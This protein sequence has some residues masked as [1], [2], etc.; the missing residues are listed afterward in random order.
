MILK[1]SETILL[2][3]DSEQVLNLTK[4]ILTKLGYNVISA[5]NGTQAFNLLVSYKKPIHLILTDVIMP[6]MNGKDLYT[7]AQEIYPQIKVLYMSGY[8]HNLINDIKENNSELTFIQK[9]FSTK[10]LAA[11]INE[12]LR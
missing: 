12:L 8:T 5:S 6:E 11:K 10:N 2:A 7:K 3:E 9:P 1:G 4:T